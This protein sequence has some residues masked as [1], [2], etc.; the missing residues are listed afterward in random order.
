MFVVR[1]KGMKK[2]SIDSE[3]CGGYRYTTDVILDTLEEF[4]NNL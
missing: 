4:C 2:T 1:A 3:F